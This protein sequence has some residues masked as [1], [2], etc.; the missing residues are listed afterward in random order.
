MLI[1]QR[2][3]R[4][5]VSAGVHALLPKHTLWRFNLLRF[6]T[7]SVRLRL[8]QPSSVRVVLLCAVGSA[9]GSLRPRP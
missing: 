8:V 5:S 2:A 6:S 4:C 1:A 9:L 3:E 7:E